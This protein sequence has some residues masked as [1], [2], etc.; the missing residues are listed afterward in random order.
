MLACGPWR[1]ST[2]GPVRPIFTNKHSRPSR[3][4]K[5]HKA[6]DTRPP[7]ERPHR[8]GSRGAERSRQGTPREVSVTQAMATGARRVQRAQCP[9]FLFGAKEASAGAESRGIKQRF[10][11]WCNKTKAARTVGRRSSRSPQQCH[12]QSLWQAKTTFVRIACTSCLPSKLSVVGFLPAY[13]WEED[14]GHYK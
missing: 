14:Q 5:P 13:V 1:G 12:H 10:L 11:Y 9:R 2:S 6:D 4:A 8:A 3:G 7:R